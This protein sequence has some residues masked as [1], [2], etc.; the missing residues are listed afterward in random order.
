MPSAKVGYSTAAR[1][2]FIDSRR[3][4]FSE[5]EYSYRDIAREVGRHWARKPPAANTIMNDLKFL[6][7]KNDV[8]VNKADAEL[9]A[10]DN[11]RQWRAHFFTAPNGKPY[12][13]TEY[14][15]AL[16]HIIAALALKTEVPSWV[17]E[18][19]GLEV[20]RT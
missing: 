14:H 8:S 3:S 1:R 19:W 13:T 6:D 7:A 9:L 10:P 5:L 17:L 4:R 20:G 2:E 15:M 11:F 12:L 18:F 16:F